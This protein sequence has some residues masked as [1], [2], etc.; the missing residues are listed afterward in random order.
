[1]LRVALFVPT[2]GLVLLFW[3]TDLTSWDM[4]GHMHAAAYYRDH[5]WPR[6]SGWNSTQGFGGYPQGYFY[7][8]LF[9]WMVGGL[10]KV[11]P[12]SWA[13]RVVL[14]ASIVLLPASGL[15][16]MRSLQAPRRAAFGAVF[17]MLSALLLGSGI[18]F[19]GFF[20]ATFSGGLVTAQF[21][22]PFVFFYLVVLERLV[23]GWRGVMAAAALLAFLVLSHGVESAGAALLSAVYVPF[24]AGSWA[25]LR[26]VLPRLVAHALVALA[27]SAVFVGPCLAY[28]EWTSGRP[29]TAFSAW[30]SVAR[31]AWFFLPAGLLCVIAVLRAFRREARLERALLAPALLFLAVYVLLNA[32]G[33]T[34]LGAELPVHAYRTLLFVFL[35]GS[36]AA[37]YT[38][39]LVPFPRMAIGA[40]AAVFCCAIALC[41]MQHLSVARRR[42]GEAS[43]PLPSTRGLV[44]VSLRSELARIGSPHLLPAILEERGAQ[45]LNGVFVESSAV[46]PYVNALLRE[47]DPHAYVGGARR[48]R[49]NPALARWHA[50]LLGVQWMLSERSPSIDALGASSLPEGVDFPFSTE[51][52][53]KHLS[54]AIH[55]LEHP[56]AEFFPDEP[57]PVADDSWP[58][59]VPAWWE[60]GAP[61]TRIPLRAASLPA[62]YGAPASDDRVELRQ[63]AR[64]RYEVDIESDAPRWVYVKLPYFPTWHAWQDGSEVPLY[65]A[66]VH[67]IAVY[68]RGRIE[69]ISRPGLVERVCAATS[70]TGWSVLGLLTAAPLLRRRRRSIQAWELA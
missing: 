41:A 64:D 26:S 9:A 25:R 67:L 31:A 2:V 65:E 51:G 14:G 42:L 57:L 38:W 68:G 43:V 66:S 22:L 23:A 61:T 28:R 46:S 12:L 48:L 54:M 56:L 30:G 70:L 45:L 62:A 40:A 36:M 11:V 21:A 8:P 49:P 4:A 34:K 32:L 47:L 1:M 58:I 29:V 17:F 24:F 27:L 3:R 13:A 35:F 50:S 59:V 33:S 52:G 37:G 5:L 69:L 63:L 10:G 7:P 6:F 16:F 15:A 55:R 18:A 20:G 44:D 60:A 53:E 19:G 39:S